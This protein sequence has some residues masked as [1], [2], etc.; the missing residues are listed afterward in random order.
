[1]VTIF[2]NLSLYHM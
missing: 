2:D 1:V